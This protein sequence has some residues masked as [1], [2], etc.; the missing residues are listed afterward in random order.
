VDWL[1]DELREQL[2]DLRNAM[3]AAVW[4]SPE[5]ANAMAAVNVK[6][7]QARIEL[8]PTLGGWRI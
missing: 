3:S 1:V 7:R 8:Y 4:N 5:V 2:W 6:D